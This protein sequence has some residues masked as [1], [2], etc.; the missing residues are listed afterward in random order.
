MFLA[1]EIQQQRLKK[2]LTHSAHAPASAEPVEIESE[3]PKNLSYERRMVEEYKARQRVLM[4]L[5]KVV[6]AVPPPPKPK[7][8]RRR[9]IIHTRP[10]PSKEDDYGLTTDA[11]TGVT[12]L[13]GVPQS[14][15]PPPES[16][17]SLTDSKGFDLKEDWLD[18]GKSDSKHSP[19]PTTNNSPNMKPS[20][21]PKPSTLTP[22]LQAT[23]PEPHIGKC[24]HCKSKFI[25]YK[26]ELG[27][28]IFRHGVYKD[29]NQPINPHAPKEFCDQM[30]KEG[31]IWGCGKP[32]KYDGTKAEVCDYQ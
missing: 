14:H 18:V 30:V 11:P 32:F 10:P 8:A 26:T 5:V 29:S 1:F 9:I 2:N 15:P 22:I 19:P 21:A 24:P 12:V 23:E 4:G 20:P 6:E 3:L 17:D 25:V 31:K 27:C 13:L 28:Q 7:P 16:T